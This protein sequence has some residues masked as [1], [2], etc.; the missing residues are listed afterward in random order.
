MDDVYFRLAGIMEKSNN[1]DEAAIYYAKIATGYPFSK[2]F[3]EAKNHLKLL[4]K[5]VPSVDTQ[6]A[7][8]NKSRIKPAEGFLPLKPFIEFGKALGFVGSPDQYAVAK[9][10]IEAEKIKTAE[11]IAAKTAGG[12]QPADDIQIETIL[13][14]DASGVTRE[15]TKVGA[16]SAAAPQSSVDKK[17]D[18]GKSR[19]KKVKKGL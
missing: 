1:P 13:R 6:L 4:G 10:T 11:A 17:K 14:K 16:S 19:K 15:T 9:K 3:E 7:A 8:L 18:T 2:F 5:P 12:S